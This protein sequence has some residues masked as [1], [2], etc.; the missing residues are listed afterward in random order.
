MNAEEL[1]LK[2]NSLLRRAGLSEVPRSALIGLVAI[3]VVVILLGAW[4]FWPRPS[5]DFIANANAGESAVPAVEAAEASAATADI[6][7]DVEGAVNAPGLYALPADSRI[8]DAIEAAGGLA[9]NAVAG[10]ANLAQKVTDGEQV[11]I[12]S[13]EEQK[14]GAAQAPAS[15]QGGTAGQGASEKININTASAEELQ[16]LSGVGPSLSERI[17]E[18]RQSNGRFSSIEELQ[19]V[20]GI[21]KTRFENIKGK[22]CV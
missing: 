22:I 5:S 6:V 17:I 14:R 11:H 20:S 3:G 10:A 8:G 4:H 12:I 13:V 16:Q 19:N 18:Y 15:A 1:S 2:A 7:V 9:A 21:G